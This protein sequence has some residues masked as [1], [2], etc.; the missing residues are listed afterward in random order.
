MGWLMPSSRSL[1][2]ATC[3]LLAWGAAIAVISTKDTAF[4]SPH[5]SAPSLST[6]AA[7]PELNSDVVSLVPL[8]FRGL[9]LAVS[10][11][12]IVEPAKFALLPR[13]RS[14]FVALLLYQFVIFMDVFR[15]LAP[16]WTTYALSFVGIIKLSSNSFDLSRFIIPRLGALPSFGALMIL[17]AT[18]FWLDNRATADET[19]LP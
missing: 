16:D 9:L 2:A 15:S 12:L 18:I 8:L 11:V 1:F 19:S 7:P 17:L 6:V 14:A 13:R 4:L 5:A 10:C 3:C